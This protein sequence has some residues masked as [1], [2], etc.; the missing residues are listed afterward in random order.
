[1]TSQTFIALIVDSDPLFRE[2]LRRILPEDLFH[3]VGSLASACSNNLCEAGEQS[4]DLILL[5]ARGASMA[6]VD[7]VAAL[8]LHWPCARIVVLSNKH[9]AHEVA[10][11]FRAGANAYLE[12]PGSL[13]ALVKIIELVMAG[14]MILTT[15]QLKR[16]LESELS[17]LLSLEQSVIR[18]T[19]CEGSLDGGTDAQD[20]ERFACDIAMSISHL[21]EREQLI[22]A[23]LVPGSSNKVIARRLGITES[24]VKVH[25]RSIMQ[26]IRASNRTQA[27]IWATKNGIV[28]SKD[29]T[30]IARQNSVSA[31]SVTRSNGNHR[32]DLAARR[33]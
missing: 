25:M 11:V 31:F 3:K 7:E 30:E 15:P 22:L 32:P 23:M 33:K 2:G 29:C 24:T 4:P 9:D 20:T 6:A 26:K 19:D 21:S 28:I 27:A 1:M 10:A 14:E 5:G 8:H 18:S 17:P 12:Q 16:I 13:D